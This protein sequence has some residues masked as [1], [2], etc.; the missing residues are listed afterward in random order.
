MKILKWLFILAVIVVAGFI[1]F[2]SYMGMFS[3]PLISERNMGPYAVVYE[4]YTGPYQ[5]MGK[6]FEKINK[7]MKEEGIE[8][9][10]GLGIYLDDPMKVSPDK[11]RA[12]GGIIIEDKDQPKVAGLKQKYSVM[13]IEVA[14][15]AVIEFPVKNNL[16]YM[17]GPIKNYTLL[18]KYFSMKNYQMGKSYEIYDMPNKKIFYV[19]EIKKSE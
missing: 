10:R 17:L 14:S 19:M 8:A 9:T 13:E 18:S 15:C 12:Q 6:V 16:S 4:E 7:E 1:G 11:L 5:N 2:M 3:R